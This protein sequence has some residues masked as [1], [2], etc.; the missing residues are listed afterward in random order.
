MSDA[1]KKNPPLPPWSRDP[2]QLL[3][4]GF[5]SGR[6]PVAPGT[7]G[8]V[9]G[10]LFYLP[11]AGLTPLP[12]LAITALLFVAGIPICAYAARQFGVH[13]H[14]AIVWDEIVGYLVTMAFAPSGWL[15]I[16]LGFALFRLFDIW[17]PWPISWLDRRVHGGLGIMVDD[18]LAGIYAAAALMLLERSGLLQF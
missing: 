17:K 10:I 6:A 1:S 7:F 3:A 2:V 14:S 9:V 16:V 13:D 4:L 5:G 18:L 12:Y 11:M 15:W 8:T